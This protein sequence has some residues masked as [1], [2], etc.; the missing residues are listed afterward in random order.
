MHTHTHRRRGRERKRERRER[1]IS[2]ERQREKQ[3]EKTKQLG[4]CLLLN[5]ERLMT[6]QQRG[7]R[8]IF[9]LMLINNTCNK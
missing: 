9:L 2:K 3:R 8:F 5:P 6:L 4:V 7:D 1:D